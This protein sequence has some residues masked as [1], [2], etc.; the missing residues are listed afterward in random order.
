MPAACIQKETQ[1]RPLRRI[2]SLMMKWFPIV[3]MKLKMSLTTRGLRLN[4]NRTE[5]TEKPRKPGRPSEKVTSLGL[6]PGS[7]PCQPPR[8]SGD[9]CKGQPVH[10]TWSRGSLPSLRM[11]LGEQSL[12]SDKHM[13]SSACSAAR[14]TWPGQPGKWQALLSI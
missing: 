7:G 11:K 9:R 13:S 10:V 8:G 5:S 4:R 1:K 2:L 14:L 12:G 3:T 6:D